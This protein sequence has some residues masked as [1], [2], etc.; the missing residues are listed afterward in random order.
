MNKQMNEVDAYIIKL[1]LGKRHLG[2]HSI[3][4]LHSFAYCQP[5]IY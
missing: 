3:I 5:V 4:S 2:K 1:I